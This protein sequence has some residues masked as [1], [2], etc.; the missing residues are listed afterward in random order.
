MQSLS[1][2]EG[3]AIP[4]GAKNVDTDVIIPAEWLKTI[5]REGLGKGAFESVRA[6]PD[7]VFDDQRYAG[8]PILIA[9]D[10]LDPVVA[11]QP[12]QQPA[13]ACLFDIQY[14]REFRL[15]DTVVAKQ[16]NQHPPL[17]AG[18]PHF[19]YPAIEL[20]AQQSRHVVD[21]ESEITINVLA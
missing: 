3:R 16:M 19:L 11:L 18:Q 2:V 9:G 14:L 20:R 17:G 1:Q 7:N 5:T 15:G 13:E 4:Y 6:Q 12:V 10:P 8:S 21:E